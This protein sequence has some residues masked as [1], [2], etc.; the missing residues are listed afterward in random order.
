MAC[1]LSIFFYNQRV[2]FPIIYCSKEQPKLSRMVS[3]LPN[4]FIHVM[5]I[6]PLYPLP[7]FHDMS[8]RENQLKIRNFSILSITFVQ[9]YTSF[10]VTHYS[11]RIF[12]TFQ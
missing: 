9:F 7:L 11:K 1:L 3:N 2:S 8:Q 5:R 10:H 6:L 12:V 4:L